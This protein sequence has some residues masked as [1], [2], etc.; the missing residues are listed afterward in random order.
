MRGPQGTRQKSSRKFAIRLAPHTTLS[1]TKEKWRKDMVRM[2]L[3]DVKS[4]IAT[5]PGKTIKS[6]KAKNPR[7]KIGEKFC[8]TITITFTDGKRISITGAETSVL[9]HPALLVELN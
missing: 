5:L 3:E 7:N 4:G 9:K 6:I 1:S 2:R 8:P